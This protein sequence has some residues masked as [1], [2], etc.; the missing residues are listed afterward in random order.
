MTVS[1]SQLLHRRAVMEK[2]Y[3][4]LK[5]VTEHGTMTT[6]L[7]REDEWVNLP[8]SVDLIEKGV[9]LDDQVIVGIPDFLPYGGWRAYVTYDLTRLLGGSPAESVQVEMKNLSDDID[10]ESSRQTYI[11]LRCRKLQA[12]ILFAIAGNWG[13]Q[14][15][16][17][18]HQTLEELNK[19]L[20]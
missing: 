3:D 2:Q 12:L 11:G 20:N 18:F 13:P 5:F 4:T 19:Y 9:P 10:S 14:R 1:P 15:I 17:M 7:V 16:E 8:I 6:F